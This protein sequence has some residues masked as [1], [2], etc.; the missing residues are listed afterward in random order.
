VQASFESAGF[1]PGAL[2]AVGLF[3]VIEHIEDDVA[4]LRSVRT[5]LV[6][7][8]RV[9][10]TVPAYSWLWSSEDVA[11]GHYRRYTIRTLTAALDEAGF[12]QEF[13]SYFFWFLPP[14]ILL[15]RSLPTVF[16]FRRKDSDE[17]AR[18]EHVRSA[19]VGGRLLGGALAVEL[20]LLRR[21]R[22]P[23]GSSILAVATTG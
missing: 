13:M 19:K 3:D 23:F 9:F 7:S 8:G 14:P 15:A 5:K 10:L 4:F 17:S 1:L 22:L 16:G 11:A 21:G 20:A 12:R 2:P 6:P 18:R